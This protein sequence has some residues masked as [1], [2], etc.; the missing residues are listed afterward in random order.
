MTRPLLIENARIVDPASNTDHGGAVLVEDGRIID[1][2]LGGPVGVPDG[3]EVID[4]QGLVLAPGLIDMRV[5]VGEP[6]KEYRETLA[7]AGAAAVAGGVT[8]F[9]MMP[10]TMPVVDDGALVDFLIRRAEAQSPARILP[11]AAI[12]KGLGGQ[13]ITEFGLLKEAG[14][15][16]LTDGASSIQ[17]SALL[18]SAM[19]YAANF[20]MAFVHHL[21]DAE[22]V[23]DGVMNEGFFA[24]ILGLRGIPREA[25]TIPLARD[26]QLAALTQVRYHAAQISTAA[27]VALVQAAKTGNSRVTAGVS[28][29]NLCLN[30][31][32]I[33]RY[34]TYF[35]LNP[36]LR[37]EDDRQAMIEGLRSGA[38]DTIHSDHDPQDSEVK[39]QPFAEA[40][41]GAI[42][43]ETLLAAALRLVHSGEVDL[44]TVLRAM[45]IRPAEILGLE[46]GR[47]ARGAPADLIVFDLDHPWQVRERELRSKSRNTSFENARLQGKVMRTI[48]GGKTMFGHEEV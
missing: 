48:V 45:T 14:A 34:R 18:R 21:A 42:G 23:G 4:A 27:S 47:I 33:G 10:D 8:S 15:V 43:L 2:A 3:A 39:R 40:S 1:L 29:N 17:S 44:L 46:A 28:I 31:N 30:E 41:D 35:K 32:D 13:E 25:E 37:S 19:S 24:T 22:L 5:F 11:A 7:S 16:C 38:I 26:L 9:V 36:P 6:G 20:D 12:T